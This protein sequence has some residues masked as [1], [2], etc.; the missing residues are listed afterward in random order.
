MPRR[1]KPARRCARS[2]GA[3]EAAKTIARDADT[4]GPREWHRDAEDLD[5]LDRNRKGKKLSN[6]DWQSPTDPDA[7]IAKLKDGSG[8]QAGACHRPRHRCSGHG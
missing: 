5:R 2:F 7:R 6:T 1:W 3:T 8:L 4:Y